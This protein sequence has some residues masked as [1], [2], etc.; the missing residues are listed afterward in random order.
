MLIYINR[1]NI[2]FK[3]YIYG[4]INS[5]FLVICNKEIPRAPDLYVLAQVRSVRTPQ[6]P[7]VGS[8]LSPSLPSPLMCPL[9]KPLAWSLGRGVLSLG[10]FKEAQVRHPPP[11]SVQCL[12]CEQFVWSQLELSPGSARPQAGIVPPWGSDG[13]P[14]VRG[15]QRQRQASSGLSR[16]G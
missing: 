1:Y 7:V 15:W 10:C 14:A 6:T 8:P 5:N 16:M 13:F 3:I 2:L 9:T 11:P 12:G 4:F